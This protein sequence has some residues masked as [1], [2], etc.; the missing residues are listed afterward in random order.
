MLIYLNNKVF[1]VMNGKFMMSCTLY[2]RLIHFSIHSRRFPSILRINH[3]DGTFL[4]NI[5]MEVHGPKIH[6]IYPNCFEAGKP[7]EFI[8]C[9][10][11]LLRSKFR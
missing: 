11:N 9:G 1:Q 2:T 7:V 6:Y 5:N 8:V 3:A 4:A 10:S